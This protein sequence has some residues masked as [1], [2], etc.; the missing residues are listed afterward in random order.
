MKTYLAAAVQ[1]NSQP[2]IDSNLEEA[3]HLIR[4]AKAK[5]AF[6]VG[7]PENFAWLGDLSGR[8]EQ[9]EAISNRVPGFLSQC[10]EEFEV[11]LLGGGFPVPA[12]E[13]KVFNRA[14]LYDPEGDMLAEY[15]KIHLFDVELSDGESYHESEFVRPGDPN[16]VVCSTADVGSLGLSIC[17]D[18][19]FPELYRRLSKEGA[20]VLCVPSAFTAKTGKDHWEPLLRARAI[21][22]TCYLL[23]PAQTGRHGAK[24]WT[25]GHAMIV[26]PWGTVLEDAGTEPGLAMAEIEPNRITEVRNQIPSLEH[27]V[28]KD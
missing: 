28:L 22:N 5:G 11:Y 16:P 17:Y 2:D 9:A 12:E 24:R 1:M 19:R 8:L 4:E 26:S 25:H 20:E 3:Y 18:L 10:A 27:R 6:L 7:L 21:E 13:R 14:Q 15:N 23:A